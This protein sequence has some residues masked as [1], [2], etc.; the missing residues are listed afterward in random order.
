MSLQLGIEYRR[1]GLDRILQ[2][3]GETVEH[4]LRDRATDDVDLQDRKV[5][6]VGLANN[7][8]FGGARHFRLGAVDSFPD[9]LQCAVEILVGIEFDDDRRHPFRRIGGQLLDAFHV[10]QFDLERHHQQAFGILGRDPFVYDGDDIPG[11]LDIGFVGDRNG[12]A[13]DQAGNHH[14]DHDQQGGFVAVD[15][16]ID[17]SVHALV[18]RCAA[19]FEVSRFGISLSGFPGRPSPDMRAGAAAG[20][21]PVGSKSISTNSP[22][23]T[24]S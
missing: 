3:D 4:P 21:S 8:L 10:A 13:G 19:V 23:T 2:F 1:Y 6:R 18:E 14:H 11:H 24:S 16:R 12:V 5:I 17:N 20:I 7:G 22:G 9:I 15:R